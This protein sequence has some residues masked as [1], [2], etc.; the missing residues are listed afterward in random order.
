MKTRVFA[1]VALLIP[2]ALLAQEFRGTITGSVSDPQEAMIPNVKIVATHTETGARSATVSDSSGTY[3]I[4]FLAPGIYQITADAPGFKRFVREKFALAVG[5]RPVLDIRMQVGD[6]SQT[7]SVIAEA[8]LLE[9]GNGSVGQVITAQEVEDYPLYGRTPLM[10]AQLSMGIVATP[11]GTG[12]VGSANPYDTTG[13]TQFSAGGAPQKSNELLLNGAPD[14][15]WNLG[16][17]Y[18]PPQDAVREV[19]VQVFEG[20]AAYGHTGGG[21]ANHITKSG[22]NAFHG[23]AYEFNRVSALAAMPFFSNKAGL[24]K[25]VDNYNQYGLTA[26][27]PVVVPK[28]FNGRNKAFWFFAWESLRSTAPATTMMT[29]PTAAER[30]GD[31]SAL[32]KVGNNYQLYDPLSGVMSGSQVAR[33]MFANNVIPADRLNRIAQ[34]YMK[35]YPAP[36]FPGGKDGTNNYAS[37]GPGNKVF[38]NGFGR[39]DFNLRDRYKLFWDIRGNATENRSENYFNND[40][41]GYTNARTNWGTTLDYVHIVNPTT[42][43]DVRLNWARFIQDY[44]EPSA[45][46]DP[47]SLGFPSYIAANSQFLE[48]PVINFSGDSFQPLNLRATQTIVRTPGDSFQIFGDVVKVWRGQT[49]K[50]GADARE[51]RMS[52]FKPGASTGSYTFGTN[53]TRGPQANSAAAPLGQG[54]ASF[55]LGLPTAGTYDLNAYCTAQSKYLALFLQDDWRAKSNLTLNF[56]IRYEHETPTTERYNRVVNGFDPS[57][58]SPIAAAAIAAYAKSPIPQ[59]PAGQF[60]APGGLTFAGPNDPSIYHTESNI[61]SPRFGFAWTPKVAGGKTVIRGGTGVFVYPTGINGGNAP[62]QQ[63][64]SQTT[65]FQAT[66]N[67]YLSPASTLSDPFPTGIQRPVGSTQGLGTFLGQSISFFNP[68][69]RNAYS[70]RWVFGIQRQLPGNMV[71]EAAYIGNHSVHLPIDTQL[72]AIPQA[73]LSK[74]PARDQATINLLGSSVTNPFAGLLPG[75]TSLN[76]GTVALSQLLLPFPQ[77]PSGGVTMQQNGAGSSYYQSF[78]VRAQ[79]RF[80][81]GLSLIANFIWNK[82]LDR[83]VYLNTYDFAPAKGVSADSR[84]LRFVTASTYQLPV[85]NGKLINLGSGWKNGLLGGWVLNGIYTWQLGAPLSW[86]NVLYYGGDLHLDAHRVDGPTFDTT[87]FNTVS[88]QQLASNIRAFPTTFNNLRADGINAFNASMIK[89][90]RFAERKELQVRLE[91]FNVLNHAKFAA[92]NVSPTNSNF[93]LITSQTIDPRKIQMG[94]RLVW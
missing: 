67:N 33:Q 69:V 41:M 11:S 16:V 23:T 85:G 43:V 73:Y 24:P 71:L 81:G 13:P 44:L 63:G 83:M 80:S 40:A 87:R 9:I 5:E 51:Y 10:L 90:F 53:W 55:L 88:A 27:G 59:I 1:A 36:N 17:A 18:N 45:G 54:F 94:V 68:S 6:S 70:I 32:L 79:K 26:G 82:L 20:D 78:N 50:F 22:T 86:G 72:N 52:N 89:K 25:P 57:S 76:G 65:Q 35:F 29:V 61:F 84:P 42:V 66:L 77:F 12:A 49:L 38:D 39:L 60:R 64:F 37:N 93:G 28:V 74:S 62:N 31:F 8:P 47:T 15:T 2:A 56:G 21:T 48:I 3:T 91:A 14:G 30:S 4:P 7:V 58:P 46:F 75:S 19:R 92:P 34:A